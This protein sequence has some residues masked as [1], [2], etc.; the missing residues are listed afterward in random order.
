MTK[1]TNLAA[2]L[3]DA[4][5]KPVKHQMAITPNIPETLRGQ[6]YSAASP[7]RPASRSG[8]RVVTF[9]VKPEAHKQLRLLGVE[10]G[11]S[12]QELMIEALNDLF[13]KHGKSRI[14]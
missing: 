5:A 2:A 8:Q 3:H 11:S 9:Y 6:M 4:G 1:R 7:T 14:A 13:S 10:Q 12:I